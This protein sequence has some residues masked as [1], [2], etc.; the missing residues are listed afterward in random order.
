MSRKGTAVAKDE[1]DLHGNEPYWIESCRIHRA[2]VKR[3]A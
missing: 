1:L 3:K 2:Q